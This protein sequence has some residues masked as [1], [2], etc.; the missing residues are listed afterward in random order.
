MA[1]SE[2]ESTISNLL[3]IKLLYVS[4]KGLKAFV[5]MDSPKWNG[6]QYNHLYTSTAVNKIQ[7]FLNK[8]K[9]STDTQ[10]WWCS[11]HNIDKI[12]KIT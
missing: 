1:Q 4:I 8:S 11:N 9:W 7:D 12:S 5:K 3:N 10:H 6:K 2:N